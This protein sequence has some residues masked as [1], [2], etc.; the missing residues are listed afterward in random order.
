LNVLS[1]DGFV[2]RHDG[3]YLFVTQTPF[4]PVTGP[5][6]AGIRENNDGHAGRKGHKQTFEEATAN[7]RGESIAA[8]VFPDPQR[9]GPCG[10]EAFPLT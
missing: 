7:E 3:R 8:V 5:A 1:K 6:S 4:E 2:P 10:Q 9:K